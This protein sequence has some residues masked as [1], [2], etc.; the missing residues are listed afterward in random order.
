MRPAS[1]DTL[2][3]LRRYQQGD[4]AAA[5]ELLRI[6]HGLV[7]QIARALLPYAG[8]LDLDD[9]LVEGQ[10]GLLAAAQAFDGSLG[11]AFTTP[12]GTSI[13]RKVARAI[14]EQGRA[15]RLPCWVCEREAQLQRSREAL[16]LRLGREPDAEE[17]A[18]ETCLPPATIRT[19][20]T[21]GP[22]LLSLDAPV[23]ADD[24]TQTTLGELLPAPGDLEERVTV[25]LTAAWALKALSA[26]ERQ[27][28]ALR[29]GFCSPAPLSWAAI[30]AEQGISAEGARR[31]VMRAL[32]KLRA[33]AGV[34]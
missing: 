32:R 34:G 6:H 23:D 10:L 31:R 2:G 9:L 11:Y 24:E 30:A 18:A 16:A 28:V 22:A 25:R 3:C 8:C 15:I 14:A 29:C 26:K 1:G 12:V 13:Y 19:L 4:A 20:Q 7:R 5:E 33:L 27:A 17:L 21:V